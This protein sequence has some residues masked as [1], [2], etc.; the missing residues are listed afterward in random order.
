MSATA[1]QVVI[2]LGSLC[3]VWGAVLYIIKEKR[4]RRWS[5]TSGTVLHLTPVSGAEGPDTFEAR[6]EFTTH[7]GETVRFSTTQSSYPPVA[8]VG[9]TVPVIY[10][11]ASPADAVVNKFTHRHL[12]EMFLFILGGTAFLLMLFYSKVR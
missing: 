3:V 2:T 7:T 5:K 9:G 6:I 1:I 11:P 4:F 12:P 8:E 10:D